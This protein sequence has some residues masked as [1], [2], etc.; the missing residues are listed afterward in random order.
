MSKEKPAPPDAPEEKPG[1]KE[2]EELRAER[3]RLQDL[4]LRARAELENFRKRAARE[5]L[6]AAAAAKRDLVA[7]LLPA[8]DALELAVRHG[9][10]DPDAGALLEG[11]RAARDSIARALA[12]QG[13]ERIRAEGGYDPDLHEAR[14]VAETAELPDGHIVEELRPGYRVGGL[15]ARHSEVVVAKRP[16]EKP[17][18]EAPAGDDEPTGEEE[19]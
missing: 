7:A 2:M 11:V 19:S 1:E 9:E 12:A 16:A 5:R 3:D 6:Q 15:V 8:L 17:S 4:H 10:E 18:E 14:A 13:V